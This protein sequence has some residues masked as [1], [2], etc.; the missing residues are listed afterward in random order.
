MFFFSREKQKCLD[1][2]ILSLEIINIKHSLNTSGYKGGGEGE[3][4]KILNN[5]GGIEKNY[6]LMGS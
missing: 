3:D 2:G 6:I 1:V 4:F 5:E